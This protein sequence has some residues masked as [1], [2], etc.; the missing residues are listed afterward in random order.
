MVKIHRS[1]IRCF[2]AVH[3]DT[4]FFLYA[5]RSVIIILMHFHLPRKS[6]LLKG[7]VY[8]AHTFFRTLIMSHIRWQSLRQP[9]LQVALYLSEQVL[10][11]V[12]LGQQHLPFVLPALQ[13]V[14]LPLPAQQ[15]RLLLRL[16]LL[17]TLLL[18]HQP[19]LLLSLRRR[20]VLVQL[21]QMAAT[22]GHAGDGSMA[23]RATPCPLDRPLTLMLTLPCRRQMFAGANRP[24]RKWMHTH[25]LSLS[26][27]F[28]L[29]LALAVLALLGLQQAGQLLLL[30]VQDVLLEL[31]FLRQRRLGLWT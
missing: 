10:L 23:H 13:L 11:Q 6:I 12:V 20:L 26:H 27:L 16:L 3:S 28:Q 9:R 7:S 4:F 18:S 15:P 8:S 24:C 21:L 22:A 29:L 19:F 17:Q 30:L 2:L 14:I 1:V 25:S 5:G 31:L